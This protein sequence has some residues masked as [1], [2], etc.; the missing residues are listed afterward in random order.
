MGQK[1]ELN[2]WYVYIH[3]VHTKHD[4]FYVGIGCLPNR[5]TST[6]NRSETWRVKAK[7]GFYFLILHKHLSRGDAKQMEVDYILKY[8]RFDLGTG[9]L[10]NLNAGGQGFNPSESTRR[11]IG[12]N[13]KGRVF[14]ETWRRNLSISHIGQIAHNKGVPA[15]PEEARRLKE[16][17]HN[18]LPLSKEG[19]LKISIASSKRRHT[20]AGKKKLSDAKKGSRNPRYGKKTTHSPEALE[21]MRLAN[22]GKRHTPEAKVK[23][24][25]SALNR[26]RRESA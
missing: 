12:A 9:N 15:T 25:L 11:K 17:R 22:L 23:M 1:K 3:Y 6:R 14:S 4:P 5:I 8:G 16:M 7:T 19:R 21:K 13:N 24:R 10:V 20:D 18:Q 2:N 26:Y